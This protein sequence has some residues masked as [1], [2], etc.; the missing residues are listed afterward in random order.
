MANPV[1]FTFG[2]HFPGWCLVTSRPRMMAMVM[3]VFLVCPC[4]KGS[5]DGFCLGSMLL[6]ESCVPSPKL[7]Y[8]T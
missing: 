7:I 5:Q 2:H 3:Y 1:R 8:S 6:C 4:S